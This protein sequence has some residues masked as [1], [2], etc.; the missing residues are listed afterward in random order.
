[1]N[2]SRVIAPKNGRNKAPVGRMK[3]HRAF[4][5]SRVL[6]ERNQA[7]VA[8]GAWVEGGQDFVEHPAVSL[9]VEKLTAD[10]YSL[11]T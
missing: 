10:S 4:R 7:V 8:V 1:M 2:A 6:A 9:E 3:E 5:A 11:L